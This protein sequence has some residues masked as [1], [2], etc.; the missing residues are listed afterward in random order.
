MQMPCSQIGS[1]Q[2]CS[3]HRNS[4]DH[5]H[6]VPNKFPSVCGYGKNLSTWA[7]IYSHR[8][9]K[10]TRHHSI[11]GNKTIHQSV[12]VVTKLELINKNHCSSIFAHK[13]QWILKAEEGSIHCVF[14]C[15]S[16]CHSCQACLAFFLS[17]TK[18]NWMKCLF[19][20]VCLQIS[21]LK[22]PWMVQVRSCEFH[23]AW[24]LC[25]QPGLLPIVINQGSN[26]KDLTTESSSNLQY[27]LQ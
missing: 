12:A 16:S 18:T 17:F 15:C 4:H 6:I 10:K 8:T 26:N 20:E 3:P 11:S 14:A 13:S 27:L 1:L 2:N 19:V 24:G 22:I 25:E 23:H 5:L 9:N 7:A 21:P